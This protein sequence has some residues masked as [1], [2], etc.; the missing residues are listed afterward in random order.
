M[1]Q[2]QPQY[3]RREEWA[4]FAER[5]NL[6]YE[7]LELFAPPVLG[8]PQMEADCRAWYRGSGRVR[9]L[10]GAFIDVNPA[11]G[12]PLF[13]ELSQ[14]RCEESCRLAQE[15]GAERVIFHSGV[16]PFLRGGYLENWA[17]VCAVFYAELAAA[18][19]MEI[20][21]ENSQELDPT[22]LAM[23]LER[24]PDKR[25]KACLDIGHAHYSQAPV[26]EWFDR[27]GDRIGAIHLS[28]NQGFFDDHL[29]LGQGSV[30]WAEA[31]AMWRQLKLDC[32]LT[33]EVGG[34][35][36]VEDSIRYLR[37]YGYFGLEG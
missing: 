11:S 16:H 1:I 28:D 23:L 5:E 15:L 27:L 18:F 17:N 2:I 6:T 24:T 33:L 4:C 36:G 3:V 13:R 26:T 22:Q 31:D 20:C 21:V 35:S 25:V 10:H 8:Q 12:D 30:N 9:S 32:P 34:I 19:D 29:P 37:K 7:V 14:K